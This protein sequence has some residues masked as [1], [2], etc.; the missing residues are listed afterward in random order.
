MGVS[1]YYIR[2]AEINDLPEIQKLFV[3]TISSICK[4]DYS[5]EQIKAWT[6]SMDNTQ[7]WI[8]KLVSQYFIVAVDES[9]ILGYASLENNNY[10]DMF[11]VHKD[12]QRQGIAK[13]LFIEVKK[14]S[15]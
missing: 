15:N 11:Y 8:T 7:R 12:F 2:H 1:K 4:Y 9:Q 3:D 14:R 13:G 10:L 5:Q 6:S